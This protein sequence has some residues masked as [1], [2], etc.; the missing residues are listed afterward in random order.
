MNVIFILQWNSNRF[1]FSLLC[2]YFLYC[3]I[4]EHLIL[5]ILKLDWKK[6]NLQG[7]TVDF[8]MDLLER[9]I[10]QSKSEKIRNKELFTIK[11]LDKKGEEIKFKENKFWGLLALD[12]DVRKLFDF[13][14]IY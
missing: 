8:A 2:F 9:S 10:V 3:R 6:A 4:L 13:G 14:Y 1:I 11:G 12:N 7:L 5:N